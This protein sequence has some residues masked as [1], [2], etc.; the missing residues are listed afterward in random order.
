MN[1]SAKYSLH[2]YC[3]IGSLGTK[4]MMNSGETECK[5]STKNN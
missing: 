4:F 1:V 3:S 5:V 2:M